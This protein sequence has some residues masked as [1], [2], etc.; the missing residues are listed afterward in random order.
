MFRAKV[1][2]CAEKLLIAVETLEILHTGPNLPK[3]LL[4]GQTLFSH[5]LSQLNWLET[6][7]FIVV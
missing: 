2:I 4:P 3:Y 7:I 6:L 1:Q 5:K